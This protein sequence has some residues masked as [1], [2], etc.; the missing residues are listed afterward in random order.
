M[1]VG[2][3]AEQ[4]L[5]RGTARASSENWPA[6]CGHR[7]IRWR[8]REGVLRAVVKSS[9][10]ENECTG[11]PPESRNG[12]PVGSDEQRRH[13]RPDLHRTPAA[14]ARDYLYRAITASAA[15]T[16]RRGTC[17]ASMSASGRGCPGSGRGGAT[18]PDCGSPMHPGILSGCGCGARSSP[19]ERPGS[20]GVASPLPH[21]RAP[22]RRLPRAVRSIAG[23][24]SGWPPM[25][26]W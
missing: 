25:K 2:G 8:R 17:A 26:A 21:K 15:P 22:A 11:C 24:W 23:P 10:Y 6:P 7:F 12:Y 14:L 4:T 18:A 9:G 13:Q 20:L 3:R 5:L 16:R 1:P 19:T